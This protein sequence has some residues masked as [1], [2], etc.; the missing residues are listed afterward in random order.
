MNAGGTM[1]SV[2]GVITGCAYLAR[3][4]YVLYNPHDFEKTLQEDDALNNDDDNI[5]K[6]RL[7]KSFINHVYH[8]PVT[9]QN[10][11]F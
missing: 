11:N 9:N 4:F 10:D 7:E 3:S 1:L 2:F 8:N 5:C 6:F